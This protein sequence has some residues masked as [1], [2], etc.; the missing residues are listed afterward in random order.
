MKQ[1]IEVQLEIVVRAKLKFAHSRPPCL[2]SKGGRRIELEG[3][4]GVSR[5]AAEKFFR[6]PSHRV[7]EGY[8]GYRALLHLR[9]HEP[10]A[11]LARQA[12][13]QPQAERAKAS[14]RSG[15]RSVSYP[16]TKAGG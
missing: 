1:C 2:L 13:H 14:E 12:F 3:H 8:R 10:A 5:G 16:G 9:P 4:P 6:R 11:K 7:G 15:S